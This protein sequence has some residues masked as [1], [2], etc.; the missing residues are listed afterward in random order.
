MAPCWMVK[1]QFFEAVP[2]K[3]K[4]CAPSV[5]VF[6]FPKQTLNCHRF[7]VFIPNI[8]VCTCCLTPSP[9]QNNNKKLFLNLVQ[10]CGNGPI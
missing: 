6:Y 10:K 2:H 4:L 5:V 9:D 8:S 3:Y 7:H 1:I